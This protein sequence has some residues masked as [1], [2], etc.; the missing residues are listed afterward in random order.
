MKIK[1]K[2]FTLVELLVVIVIM[3]VLLGIAGM[4]AAAARGA[5]ARHCAVTINSLISKC[6]TD[7][8]SRSGDFSLTFTEKDGQV[9]ATYGTKDSNTTEKICGKAIKISYTLGGDETNPKPLQNTSLSLAFDR[10]TG[11]QKNTQKV[12]KII[13]NGGSKTFTIELGPTTGSHRIV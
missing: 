11:G 7:S 13:V 12:L 3:G 6:R 9:T 10:A 5:D 4:S 8:M 1:N 2:G